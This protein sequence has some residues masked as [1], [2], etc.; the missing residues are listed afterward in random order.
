VIR[1]F[2]SK[3]LRVY[4]ETGKAGGLSVQNVGRVGR[5][6]RA[7]DAAARPE[8]MN[9]PGYYFHSL[10]GERRWSIRVTGNWRITFGWDGA[11]AVDVDLEDYH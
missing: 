4:F 5:A 6:L 3:A 9:L 2:R 7:L 1:T 8:Q 10:R 11:D